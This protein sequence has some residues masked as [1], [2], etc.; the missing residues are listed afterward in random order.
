M[1]FKKLKK[2]T[3]INSAAENMKYWKKI[4]IKNKWTEKKKKKKICKNSAAE[5]M[6]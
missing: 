2:Q 3:K 5:N 4:I 6:K 1:I